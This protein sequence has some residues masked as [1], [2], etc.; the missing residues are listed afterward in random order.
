MVEVLKQQVGFP[1]VIYTIIT[2]DGLLSGISE[3]YNSLDFLNKGTKGALQEALA[4]DT[5]MHPVRA[6][7]LFL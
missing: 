1:P 4:E 7:L 3:S 6:S 2:V 5:K